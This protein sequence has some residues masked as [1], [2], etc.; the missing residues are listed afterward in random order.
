MYRPIVLYLLVADYNIRLDTKGKAQPWKCVQVTVI[1]YIS[2]LFGDMGS[3]N[4]GVLS[5][6]PVL[7]KNFAILCNVLINDVL[8]FSKFP[9]LSL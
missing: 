9:R 2:Y 6:H 3:V 7:M 8:E 1:Y 5:K 4:R